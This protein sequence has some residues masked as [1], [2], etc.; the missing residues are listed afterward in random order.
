VAP[1]TGTCTESAG[2]VTATL[3]G[4]IDAGA[5]A[6]IQVSVTVNAAATGTLTDQAS[7]AYK[8][9]LG[10]VFPVVTASDVD[11]VNPVTLPDTSS[12][13]SPA[14]LGAAAACFLIGFA[15]LADMNQR[16]RRLRGFIR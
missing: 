15:I 7:V 8:D 10:N 1:A 4:W 2:V 6:T 3:G 14:G 9:V 13:P 11:A 5:T 12:G 16:A